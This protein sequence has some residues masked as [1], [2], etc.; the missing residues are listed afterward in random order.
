MDEQAYK[1]T[2][3]D[4]N[5]F[6]CPFGKAM[7]SSRCACEKFQKLNIAEREAAS[8]I[9][10]QAHAS[11][12]YLLELLY[13]KTRFALG[14]VDLDQPIPHAKAMRTQCGGILGLRELLKLEHSERYEVDNIYGLV[15]TAIGTYESLDNL[16]FKEIVSY[17][18]QYKVRRRK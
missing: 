11:C 1:S 9:S 15:Q 10:P 13:L 16:P 14:I 18:R 17:V 7:L 8:C 2:F 12:E 5:P 4:I 3:H 6:P